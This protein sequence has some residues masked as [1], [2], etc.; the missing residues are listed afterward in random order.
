MIEY[1]KQGEIW[2]EI[3]RMNQCYT[4]PENITNHKK[5]EEL[6]NRIETKFEDHANTSI[7]T[8]I[9]PK[10][11]ARCMFVEKGKKSINR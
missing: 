6:R 9:V 5:Y 2:I 3:V 10:K 7:L 4:L 11:V 8:V 1:H